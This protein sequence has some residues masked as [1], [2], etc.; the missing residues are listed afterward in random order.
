MIMWSSQ[1]RDIIPDPLRPPFHTH[2]HMMYAHPM[3]TLFS[4]A[5]SFKRPRARGQ[6]LAYSSPQRL[7]I[8]SSL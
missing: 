3:G 6:A 1:V 8:L 2:P 5:P 4:H 7:C